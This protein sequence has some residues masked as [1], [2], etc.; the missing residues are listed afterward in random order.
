MLRLWESAACPGHWCLH[1]DKDLKNHPAKGANRYPTPELSRATHPSVG[2]TVWKLCG[3]CSNLLSDALS[4]L[5]R[6]CWPR[7]SGGTRELLV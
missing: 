5:L 7:S 3:T 1:R 4:V 2:R 6:G